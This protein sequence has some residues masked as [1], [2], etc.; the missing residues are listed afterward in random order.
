MVW[1]NRISVGS[2]P[3]KR[4]VAASILA[5]C[6]L[7]LNA[8]YGQSFS[9]PEK[10]FEGDYNK[11][12]SAGATAT[13]SYQFEYKSWA[14]PQDGSKYICHCIRNL[15]KHI[16]SF[17][18]KEVGLSGYASQRG[19]LFTM[20]SYEADDTEK[21]STTI[22]YG[23]RSMGNNTKAPAV[24]PRVSI[25]RQQKPVA[26]SEYVIRAQYEGGRHLSQVSIAAV[27]FP[28][29]NAVQGKN[30]EDIEK[31]LQERPEDLRNFYMEFTSEALAEDGK[32]REIKFGCSYRVDEDREAAFG[33]KIND[34]SVHRAVFDSEEP[35][36]VRGWVGKEITMDGTVETASP[37]DDLET[38][39]S[40]MQIIGFD[41]QVL[42][43]M[44][45]R[46]FAAKNASP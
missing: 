33:I 16:T 8:A 27:S 46:Y 45:I 42:A 25:D 9:C 37:V 43:S 38:K 18:W 36:F 10:F 3:W 11:S 15:S 2:L 40:L 28:D 26:E 35:V 29:A 30:N 22:E 4:V 41:G 20:H 31:Y 23:S 13:G 21:K 34:P 12:G 5:T 6:A 44:P 17:N 14:W 19:T 32:V 39:Q 7:C 1:T 24:F